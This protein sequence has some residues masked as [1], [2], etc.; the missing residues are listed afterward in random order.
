M[1]P[2]HHH[3]TNTLEH[4]HI[5]T[6]KY[7]TRQH[8]EHGRTRGNRTQPCSA[9]F[10]WPCVPLRSLRERLRSAAFQG[11]CVLLR[12]AFCC[13]LDPA[14]CCVLR[15]ATFWLS[16]V[17][18]SRAFWI[19]RSAAFC[20][21]LR[22]GSAGSG[23]CCV[24]DPVFCE[25]SE[26]CGLWLWW[27]LDSCSLAEF[28]E[29]SFSIPVFC[30]VRVLPCSC[31][32]GFSQHSPGGHSGAQH[33]AEAVKQERKGGDETHTGEGRVAVAVLEG[34]GQ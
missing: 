18:R 24:L 15:S 1:F 31:S 22:S 14:F 2:E 11:S 19:L 6:Q 20:V 27:A 5:T 28:S 21:L 23:F 32:A 13:V 3:N 34:A 10:Q 12:S 9:A 29:P 4:E 8:T 26:F 33:A 25:S 16:C 17:L 7:R 30:R